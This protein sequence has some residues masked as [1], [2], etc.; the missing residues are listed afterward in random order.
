MGK[1][2]KRLAK[3]IVLH[4]LDE[5]RTEIDQRVVTEQNGEARP[6]IPPQPPGS[7]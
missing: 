6:P 7:W 5:A 4:G 2:L 1:L 3:W